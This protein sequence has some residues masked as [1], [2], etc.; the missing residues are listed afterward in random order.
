MYD[1][2]IGDFARA[3][4]DWERDTFKVLLLTSDYQ[5]D[6]SGH[7]TRADLG[8]FEI[9]GSGS[10]QRGGASLTG[11]S[12]SERSGVTRLQAGHVEWANVTAEFRFAVSRTA[13]RP[14][15]VWCRMSIS[16]APRSSTTPVW[17]SSTPTAALSSS[18]PRPHNT[19][20]EG[21]TTW[22]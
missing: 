1:S 5:P 18:W 10:Y 8:G 6:Q 12:V 11:R 17:C 4:L 19:M 13:P 7:A 16:A 14:R 15:I 22:R 20:S 21:D 9:E 2:V 3:E